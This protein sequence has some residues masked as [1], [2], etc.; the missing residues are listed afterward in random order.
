MS[1]DTS[2]EMPGVSPAGTAE[3]RPGTPPRRGRRI[4]AP[5]ANAIENHMKELESLRRFSEGKIVGD[6]HGT[7][8]AVVQFPKQDKPALACDGRLWK[9]IQIRMRH[10]KLMDLG[11]KKIADMF[12]A[13]AQERIL[14]RLGF[15][16]GL[17]PGIEYILD[18]TPPPEGAELAD[19]TAALWLPR[20]VKLWFL[21]GHYIPDSILANGFGLP[22]RPLA[23]KAVG[24]TLAL[25]HDDDCRNLGCTYCAS[26]APAASVGAS[27]S[28][29]L[30]SR[31]F[32]R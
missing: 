15:Q 26:P 8:L 10:D 12:T 5:V 6:D 11:S 13:K 29:T 23:D 14:R 18:F 20:V 31:C 9:D 2:I 32:G 4:S 1:S 24:A 16:N 17:P 30:L 3:A 27:F 28:L 19:L 21:A 25:G 7:V 22:S